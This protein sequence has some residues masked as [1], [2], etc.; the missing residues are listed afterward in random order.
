MNIISRILAGIQMWSSFF[1]LLAACVLLLETNTNLGQVPIELFLVSL[2]L[3][4][5]ICSYKIWKYDHTFY[6]I[7]SLYWLLQCVVIY[8]NL[9]VSEL[10]TILFVGPIMIGGEVFDFVFKESYVLTLG[11]NQSVES[12]LVGVNMFAV[13][14]CLSLIVFAKVSEAREQR[15]T[16]PHRS[17]L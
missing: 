12:S 9:V 5:M 14:M 11:F 16:V 2:F 8:S 10:V 6:K 13:F 1:G 7:S 17:S 3:L 4:G 15:T